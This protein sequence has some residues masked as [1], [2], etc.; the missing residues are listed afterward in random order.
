MESWQESKNGYSS[1]FYRVTGPFIPSL[2][3]NQFIYLEPKNG[4]TPFYGQVKQ[5]NGKTAVLQTL[6]DFVIILPQ[7][8]QVNVNTAPAEVLSALSPGMPLADATVLVNQRK[9]GYFYLDETA[10]LNA[11]QVKAGG[12]VPQVQVGVSSSYFLAYTRVQLDRASLDSVSLLQR[13]NNGVSTV[14]WIR[15]N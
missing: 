15:E 3:V 7:A 1:T 14:I 2:L 11:P 4:E 6:R 13:S 9:Q 10:Y 12:H 5:I 8:T